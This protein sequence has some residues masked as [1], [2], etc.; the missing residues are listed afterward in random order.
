[1]IREA[2]K[3]LAR[4]RQI[5]SVVAR[6]GFGELVER[7]RLRDRLGLRA[8][9]LQ[10][11]PE[12]KPRSMARRFRE[13][14]SELGPTFIK[15]G[16]ILS[17]RADL[18]PK[19]IIEEL[20][21]LQDNVRP[22]T[23]AEVRSQIEAGLGR[24]VAEC[25]ES[26]DPVP[27]AAA[28]IAQVHR[29]RT[30][31]GEEVVVK[32]QRPNIRA[33]IG[34]DLDL[35]YYLARLLEAMVE[36]V[37]LYSPTGF[38]EEFDRAIHEELSFENEA[39]NLRTFAELNC[40]RTDLAIPKV[41]D[42]LSSGTVLTM[43]YLRGTKITQVEDLE[44]RKLLARTVV[45][46]CFQQLFEDGVFHGDPHPGNILVLEDGRIGLLDF[47]LVGRLTP[48]MKQTLVV[49]TLAIALKD[50]DTVARV[51]YRVGIP[52]SRTNL[53][54]FRT[55]IQAVLGKYLG[56]SLDQ[57]DAA[58]LLSDLFDLAVRY[59]IRVPKDYALLSRA[60]I[61]VEGVLRQ[62]DPQLDVAAIAL[63]SLRRTLLSRFGGFGAS[64][65]L[66]GSLLRGLLRLQEF[67]QD[68]PA[69]LSQVLMDLEGGKFVVNIQTPALGE[70]T[71]AIRRLSVVMMAASLGSAL[72]LGAF[73]S[74]SRQQ[75]SFHG[76]P[77][78]G[79]VAIAL[80]A[81]L[82]GAL[83]SWYFVSVRLRKISISKWRRPR[84]G[85]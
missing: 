83:A 13:L 39:Q 50:P 9:E 80:A 14:L 37:G 10:A 52:D 70:M 28:S 79:V 3:D 15:L 76:V 42:A 61:S 16:Q 63:P 57:V 26:L 20:T 35:L 4:L 73:F 77:V 48:A 21:N 24:S 44:H 51:L 56:K 40:K 53:I 36:E 11:T 54:A 41:Y 29:A 1:M 47:G 43:E 5:S 60:A 22:M 66:E 23:E 19:E 31:A 33:Q 18:L 8:E 49:L 62:L 68:V 27:L 45:T 64:E 58:S 67:A 38:V 72:V 55:D 7:A 82:F 59:R 6:H 71:A 12:Q 25:F 75:W 85:A 30:R 34:T 69:Q 78:L 46:A 84:P 81:M 17:T 74:L 65:N 32:V 2:F